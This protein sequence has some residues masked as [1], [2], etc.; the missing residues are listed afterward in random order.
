MSDEIAQVRR[1]IR[2]KRQ[3]L[4]K[5]SKLMRVPVRNQTEDE[6][7]TTD[8]LALYAELMEEMYREIEL[9]YIAS[10][11]HKSY[12]GE[13]IKIIISL[14]EIQ[15]DP[16]RRQKILTELKKVSRKY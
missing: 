12:L 8:M 4:Q 5:I 2:L 14:T 6:K 16:A 3:R 9:L 11:M 7:A 10:H 1:S 13:L 15:S